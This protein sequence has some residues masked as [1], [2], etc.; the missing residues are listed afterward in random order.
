MIIHKEEKRKSFAV[1]H[2]NLLFCENISLQAKGLCAVLEIYS[3]GFEVSFE[4]LKLRTK[5][6]DKTLRKYVKELE[7]NSFIYRIQIKY[8]CQIIWFI[9]SETLNYKYV[10][11]K[12]KSYGEVRNIRHITAYQ[13]LAGENLIGEG[14]TTYKNTNTKPSDLEYFQMMLDS[15]KEKKKNNYNSRSYIQTPKQKNQGVMYE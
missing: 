4:T 8:N 12:I 2:R 5:L 15:E 7:Q 6:S 3:D 11:N 13:F 14:I 1:V 9:N 10:I